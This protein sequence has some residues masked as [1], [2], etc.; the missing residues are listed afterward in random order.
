MPAISSILVNVIIVEMGPTLSKKKGG[1]PENAEKL[2]FHWSLVSLTNKIK[3]KG[4]LIGK[5]QNRQKYAIKFDLEIS[6]CN[7]MLIF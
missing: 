1:M 7:K 6:L 3:N 5:H 2:L 4:E